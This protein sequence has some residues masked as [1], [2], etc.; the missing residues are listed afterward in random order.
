[1]KKYYLSKNYKELNSAGNK[2]KTDIEQ[3]LQ[4]QGYRNAGW[5][6]TR[7]KNLLLGFLITLLGVLKLPFTLRPGGVLV[8]QYPLKKYYTL[9]CR[10][11]HLRGCKVVTLIHDLGSFRRKKLTVAQE[12]RRLSHADY[13]IVHNA[14]MEDWLS[15]NGCTRPMGRLEIF[16]YLSSTQAPVRNP[17]LAPYQ[18]VY[19]G[20]LGY[21]K[22]PFLYKMDETIH[23]WH[24]NLYGGGFEV[25]RIRNKTSFTYKGF[26]PSDQLI[27]SAEGHFGLVWDGESTDTCSGAFGEY[28]R[29]NN[30]HKASLYL[31][32]G[33]PV[34]VWEQAAIAA[35]VRQNEL[36]LCIRSLKELDD[37]LP[38]VALEKY[39]EMKRNVG[40]VGN[41]LASGYYC[42]RAVREAEQ[43]LFGAETI[44]AGAES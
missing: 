4:Q 27:A 40:V 15:R 2:A 14:S 11:A 6:Q 17:A 35:F 37:L 5:P 32:C 22:N 8:L 7:Y 28:L 1:M 3:I 43:H 33:L 20:G 30:P 38:S 13:L 36:G 39:E 24:F 16:D 10:L 42:A 29:Y 12:I 44:E 34:I 31:R 23:S 19:A 25:E 41:R 9:A 26:V 18:V 21:K